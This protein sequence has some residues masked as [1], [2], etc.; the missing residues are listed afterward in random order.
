VDHAIQLQQHA[1]AVQA[2]ELLHPAFNFFSVFLSCLATVFFLEGTLTMEKNQVVFLRRTFE[3]KW[4]RKTV[5][6][7]D[8]SW[9]HLR[10]LIELESGFHNGGGG[11]VSCYV[12]LLVGDAKFRK[13]ID[14]DRVV[15]F[16]QRNIGFESEREWRQGYNLHDDAV[17]QHRDHILL[18][19]VLLPRY[20]R[21]F[22]PLKYDKE[23][24]DWEST[25]AKL[26]HQC[27]K[28]AT[29]EVTKSITN[30]IAARA[31]VKEQVHNLKLPTQPYRSQLQHASNF[32]KEKNEFEVV[33][34]PPTNYLCASCGAVGLHFTNDCPTSGKEDFVPINKTVFAHGIPNTFLKDAN[35]RQAHET[36]MLTQEGQHVVRTKITNLNEVTYDDVMRE[37]RS[38]RKC[39]FLFE[40]FVAAM[41]QAQR[42]LEQKFYRAHPRLRRKGA[43]CMYGMKG[44]CKKGKLACEFDHTFSL[45]KVPVC[46][47]FLENTCTHGDRCRFQHQRQAGPLKKKQKQ[48][49]RPQQR[50][51]R[52][53]RVDKHKK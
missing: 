23:M 42:K 8:M 26:R 24:I 7:S 27:E 9:H 46:K 53:I 50:R 35:K 39:D 52:Q 29:V 36:A 33:F 47:F 31:W 2:K 16:S 37:Y 45:Q 25:V 28:A 10:Y 4:V 14:F 48:Q 11:G 1:H 20:L 49:R 6:S 13:E 17:L 32:M 43:Q 44:F 5:N 21:P 18:R 38:T 19:R 40:N 34:E 22:V 30:A 15:V 12:G 51:W 3:T 41:D